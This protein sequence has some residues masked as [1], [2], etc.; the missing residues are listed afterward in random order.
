[1][2]QVW[3]IIPTV[4]QD[5]KQAVGYQRTARK[6][7]KSQLPRSYFFV[8]IYNLQIKEKMHSYR[9]CNKRYIDNRVDNYCGDPNKIRSEIEMNSTYPITSTHFMSLLKQSIDEIVNPP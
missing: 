6:V 8:K 4:K 7:S 9:D 5:L 3:T 2:N 1:M